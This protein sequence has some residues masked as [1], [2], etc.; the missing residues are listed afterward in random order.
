MNPAWT[1]GSA[2]GASRYTA[3]WVYFLAPTAGVLLA[4]ETYLRVGRNRKVHCA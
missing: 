3:L 4:A 1:L 2:L